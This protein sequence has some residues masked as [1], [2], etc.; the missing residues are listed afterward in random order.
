MSPTTKKVL[1][2]IGGSGAMA[3]TNTNTRSGMS[4]YR[5][6]RTAAHSQFLA[7]LLVGQHLLPHVGPASLVGLVRQRFL[8]RGYQT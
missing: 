8:Q 6:E 3:G 2:C 4:E 7:T 5:L 1:L